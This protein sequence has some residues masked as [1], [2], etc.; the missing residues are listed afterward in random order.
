MSPELRRQLTAAEREVRDLE[1]AMRKYPNLPPDRNPLPGQ[2]EAARAQLAAVR[3]EITAP[4][5]WNVPAI[6]IVDALLDLP[7]V[8]MPEHVAGLLAAAI[9]A[10]LRVAANGEL[11]A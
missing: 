2:L 3:H 7:G 8:Q 1:T 10:A 6:A 4:E 5:Q 11:T 9:A